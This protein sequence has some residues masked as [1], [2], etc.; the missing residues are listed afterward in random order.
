MA[1]I[2]VV[3]PEEAGEELRRVYG[4][5]GA[6]RGKLSDIMKVQS[7]HPRAM[8]AH[9][10]LY[11]GV[12]FGRSGL[13]RAEREMAAVAVSAANGCRYCVEHHAAALRAY[14][15]DEE[16]VRRFLDDPA[17]AGLSDREGA[18]VEYAVALTRAPAEMEPGRVEAL[19]AQGLSDEDVLTLNLVAAYFNFVN[20][21]AVGLGVEP[22]PEEV[23]G[24]RY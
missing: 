22:T 6:E 23:A 4:R 12:M 19:R 15:K 11:M 9:M 7:L 8:E 1:W 5:I 2:R 13:S 3:E 18:L 14:W 10:D 20:R 17:S 16:R 24:Y 21:I